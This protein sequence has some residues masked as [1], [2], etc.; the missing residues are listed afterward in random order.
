[1]HGPPHGTPSKFPPFPSLT[2]LEIRITSLPRGDAPESIRRC[3][4]GLQLPVVGEKPSWRRM[5]S[6]Y[7]RRRKWSAFL[8]ACL[9]GKTRLEHGH[10]VPANVAVDTLSRVDPD[11]AQ[12]WRQKAPDAILPGQYFVFE[13]RACE[14]V[15]ATAAQGLKG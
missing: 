6:I 1:M 12:W 10:V 13:E 9:R 4:I 14:R 2:I 15:E 5:L 8:L 3:W 11:A 7:S